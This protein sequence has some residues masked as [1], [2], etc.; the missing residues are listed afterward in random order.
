[1][2]FMSARSKGTTSITTV[3]YIYPV[4]IYISRQYPQAKNI[5]ERHAAT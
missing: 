4:V 2:T 5:N 3:E 1:M